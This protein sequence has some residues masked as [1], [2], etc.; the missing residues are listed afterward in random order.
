MYFFRSHSKTSQIHQW[1]LIIDLFFPAGTNVNDG[2]DPG[3]CSPVYAQ[4]EEVAENILKLGDGHTS[5]AS[6]LCG[7]NKVF[8]RKVKSNC[9][10]QAYMYVM[11]ILYTRYLL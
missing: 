1:H 4:A 2:I 9:K 6:N 3:L 5:V 7:L 8:A 11:K 10:L